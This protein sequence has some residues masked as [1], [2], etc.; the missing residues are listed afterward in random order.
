[1]T[2][3]S[4]TLGKFFLLDWDNV[5][6]INKSRDE[7]GINRVTQTSLLRLMSEFSASNHQPETLGR[8]VFDKNYAASGHR[9]AYS[10]GSAFSVMKLDHNKIP[11]DLMQP[12][13][14][15]D[16]FDHNLVRLKIDA[17]DFEN[18]DR[19]QGFIQYAMPDINKEQ[20][21]KVGFGSDFN[22]FRARPASRIEPKE[23]ARLKERGRIA[24]FSGGDEMEVVNTAG[25]LNKLEQVL[26]RYEDQTHSFYDD[27]LNMHMDGRIEV[28]INPK[29][30]LEFLKSFADERSAFEDVISFEAVGRLNTGNSLGEL[31]Y[32][33]F[34]HRETDKFYGKL[35][36]VGRNS[37]LRHLLNKNFPIHEDFSKYHYGAI[38]RDLQQNPN[39][40][41]R[42]YGRP[43]AEMISDESGTR[44]QVNSI[45]VLRDGREG[46]YMRRVRIKNGTIIPNHI[47]PTQEEVDFSVC[48]PRTASI[49]DQTRLMMKRGQRQSRLVWGVDQTLVPHG[50]FEHAP[51]LVFYFDDLYR[52]MKLHSSITDVTKMTYGG[53][54]APVLFETHSEFSGV[55]VATVVG[56]M[57][58][59]TKGS[60]IPQ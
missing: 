54:F 59:T 6:N 60:V 55:K 8:V 57:D 23:Y 10:L 36:S 26:E 33:V 35:L 37:A 13:L 44:R 47:D 56:P 28:L 24:E 42:M 50:M 18:P 58:Q 52:T 34:Y 14:E 9:R 29:E 7:K 19:S 2:N 12:G 30:V 53:M 27:E 4:R 20:T 32:A 25:F 3:E 38:M 41:V 49:N 31:P 51:R 17:Q 40:S 16:E 21:V 1:M 15:N 43:H 39:K 5:D 22:N 45:K 11:F 48:G 46:V